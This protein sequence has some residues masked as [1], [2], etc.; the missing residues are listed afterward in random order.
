MK[1]QKE[2]A[3]TVKDYRERNKLTRQAFS[4]ISGIEVATLNELE[5]QYR[6][7]RYP[8]LPVAVKLANAMGIT[9]DELVGRTGGAGR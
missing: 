6:G 8:S 1:T 7:G 5:G 4:D 9:L 3:A 2:L